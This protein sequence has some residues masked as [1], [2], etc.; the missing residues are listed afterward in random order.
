MSTRI[1]LLLFR[2]LLSHINE[3]NTIHTFIL[4][5]IAD[6]CLAII[7]KISESFSNTLPILTNSSRIKPLDVFEECFFGAPSTHKGRKALFIA[8]MPFKVIN[9]KKIDK[10]PSK[11]SPVAFAW[12]K[13]KQLD[14]VRRFCRAEAMSSGVARV[15]LP[16]EQH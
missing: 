16:L 1:L 11:I 3:K 13:N 15:N 7:H 12:I 9:F 6:D 4:L 5:F 2:R 8:I 10:F 14:F